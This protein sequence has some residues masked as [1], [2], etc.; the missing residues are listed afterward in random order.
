[1]LNFTRLNFVLFLCMSIA[2]KLDEVPELG[3]DADNILQLCIETISDGNSVLIFCP[4]KKWCEKL[5]EQIATTFFKLGCEDTSIGK[6]LKKEIKTDLIHETL[7][8]L[9]RSPSGLDNVLRST[10]S[11]G[12]AFHHAGLTMDERDIIEGSFRTGSLRVLV[13]TSTLSSGVNL[14]ARR[15][16]VR[17]P[18]FG[19]TP[20]NTLTYKQMI[21][22]AGRMGKDSAGESILM[23]NPSERN[24]AMSLLSATLDPI[25]SCLNDSTLLIRALLEAVASEVLYTLEDLE[26]YIS[27]TLLSLSDQSDIRTFSNEAM[28][29]LLNN[30]FLLLQTTERES[31]WIATALGKACLAASVPPREGLILFEELQKARR[32]FVLDTELHVIYLVTPLSP[33][34]QI[35]T[36]DWMT[37]HELWN[38]MSESERRVGKLVGVEERFVMQAIRGVVR[39]GKSLNIHRRFY[40]ALALHDLV[41]EVPLN[42]V[43]KKYSCCRGVLQTL[44][45]SASTYA[46][47][48]TQFC[49]Q[50]G[51]DCME[52]LVSQFQTRLQFGVCRELLDLL[53]LPMLN[54]LRARSLYKQG[55]TCVADLAVANELNVE[56]ALY[57]ALPFE[58]EKE[59]EGEYALETEKRNKMRT[60]F[61]T[62]RDGL[63]PQQAAILLV[64]EARMLVQKELG[65]EQL[66][67]EQNERSLQVNTYSGSAESS[68]KERSQTELTLRNLER[69]KT[70]TLIAQISA[71]EE[72]ANNKNTSNEEVNLKQSLCKEINEAGVSDKKETVSTHLD[73]VILSPDMLED[74]KDLSFFLDLSSP[75]V[76]LKNEQSNTENNRITET[77][78]FKIKRGN[79]DLQN[80]ALNFDDRP[81][82]KSRISDD[83]AVDKN[84][85]GSILNDCKS[86]N[87]RSPSLFDDS[88]NL[89]TQMYNILEQNV[90][91][92]AHLEDSKLSANKLNATN[93]S[94]K[95][96]ANLNANNN[97]V[98]KENVK[99]VETVHLQSRTS[100][101]SWGD[102]SWN[103]T[104]GLLKHMVQ[105]NDQNGKNKLRQSKNAVNTPKSTTSQYTNH[106]SAKSCNKKSNKKSAHKTT[107]G[108][109]Q[110]LAVIKEK[111]P[112]KP[113]LPK[114][115][116][117]EFPAENQIITE[118]KISEDLHKTV[119]DDIIV[120]SQLYETPFSENQTR[121]KL[122]KI[123]KMRSQKISEE[124]INEETNNCLNSSTRNIAGGIIE[125]KTEPQEKFKGI[126]AQNLLFT[127]N[128]S[129]DNVVCN[130][131][132]EMKID[133]KR[134]I[135][136]TRKQLNTLNKHVNSKVDITLETINKKDVLNE[137]TDWNTLNIVKVAKS[138]ATFNLFK[139]EVLKKQSIAI[140]LHCNTYVDNTNNIGSK[141]CASD[142]KEKQ[143]SKK[144]GSYTHEDKEICGAAISWESNIAYYMSFSNSQ[145]SKVS[146]K[147]Q[148]TLLKELFSDTT[149]YIKCFATK[150]M[151][152]LLYQCCAISAKCRF[153][154]PIIAHWLYTNDFE[155]TF[156]EMTIE[157][158][159]QGN[160]IMKRI[161][162]CYNSG[163][164]IDVHSSL[165][166]EFKSA[167]K[168]VLTWHITD[169]VMT[170]LEELNPVL[171]HTFRDVE[172][173]IVIVLACMELSGIG[174]SLKSLQELSS[175]ISNE[176]H[177]LE[178]KAYESA[179]RKFNFSS[180]K[181]VGQVLGLC[182]DKKVSTSKSVLEKCDNPISSLII[183]WRKLNA[184]KTKM[185][186]PLLHLAQ[187]E[188]RIRGNCITC[189]M[190]GRVSMHE[191]NL[192]NV[193]K[194]FSFGD[195]DFVISVRMAFVPALGN[196]ILSADYCQLELRLLTHFSQDSTLCE[197]MRQ[198][199]DIFKS[200]AA[201]WNN[202][203]EEEVSNKMRQH[204]KQLCYGMIY[205]MGVKSLAETL[206]VSEPEAQEFLESFMSTYPGIYKWL[207]D[208]LEE[209]HNDGYVMTLLGRRRQFPD[210][211]SEKSSV[212]AAAERQAVNTKVQ[213]SAADIVKK[214]MITI[215][216]RMRHSFPDSAIVFP[217]ARNNRKLRSSRE[218]QQ[219]GGYLVL[220]LHDEL[221]YEVNLADLKKVAAIIKDSMENVSQLT[222]PLPV[223]IRV[224][225]AWGDLTDYQF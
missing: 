44:Q 151:Y 115:A 109:I 203:T 53:R 99:T 83:N 75:D 134:S 147:E 118:E 112:H 68:M 29:F 113:K 33:G 38:S 6:M 69:T 81:N 223:K 78:G 167:A 21:G 125:N 46:G 189:T 10:I 3:R 190:T 80:P 87:S 220:Q 129:S 135:S 11:F 19:G 110:C 111:I 157:Y 96:S 168:A 40:S 5:A 208:V 30:E 49:K 50:L 2:R 114:V 195:N 91:D 8:Q 48:V 145:E 57:N 221:L 148:I 76:T 160:F 55:I 82:K 45:Q 65:L 52:L 85:S 79:K 23:C 26:L 16:I 119:M 209:T 122:E 146:G 123:R 215:E 166:D 15:V 108:I 43:C 138:R 106:K 116:E 66:P 172:M 143:R 140:A 163:S 141:I 204:T 25:E 67:W 153:L 105:G 186:Y 207:N 164:K 42:V 218:M 225:P 103:C 120:D 216:E 131:E 169:N 60:V 224:G 212:R 128:C 56:R 133:S 24:A 132:D 34:C 101:L 156:N 180:S 217:E 202:V 159:P 71:H 4:T 77:S 198:E 170:K 139:R 31:R 9:K 7:E 35:G 205:G 70:D 84:M 63:T 142:R 39:P 162:S 171:I 158:F 219:R 104:E 206:C 14:P 12:I 88:L 100:I 214:A 89:D 94:Q 199:G 37:F 144:S 137:T 1:M 173:R 165:P 177:V 51:W 107:G 18:L 97:Q 36:V 155:K 72:L 174:V 93:T 181:E 61:V 121:T 20:L 13:A 41:K 187:K 184:T 74:N 175:V 22:R 73:E 126:F 90:M 179:G 27:C 183:L 32:C 201:K 64:Q 130:S 222:V 127:A 178:T 58:S 154:D 149:L 17:S 161:N 196:I 191:P 182:K 210:L 47:M 117:V 54:G 102:D 92:I 185:I 152:K 211:K 192:Q 197:I 98:S 200:I 136:M 124:I 28:K 188:P 95:T 62:G 86:S 194:D 193:P 213:G 176:M 150:D 59:H